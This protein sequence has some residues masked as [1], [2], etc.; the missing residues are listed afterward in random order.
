[1]EGSMHRLPGIVAATAL[2]L[3]VSSVS[4]RAADDGL[5]RI[6]STERLI[7]LNPYGDSN[8]QMYSIWC[9]IYGCLG[10]Y[11]WEQKKYVGMLAEKWEVVGPTTWRF[12]L[13]TDLKRQDG[14]PGPK[15]KDVV[16]AF[17][18]I[19]TD[20]ESTQKSIVADVADVTAVDDTTVDFHTKAPDAPFLS[21]LFDRFVVTSADL[22]ETYGKDADKKG[23][24]GWGPY[25]LEDFVLD[26]RVVL[27]R[28]DAWPGIDPKT[29]KKVIYQTIMEP[30][31]R[32]TALLNGEVEIARLIPPQLVGRLQNRP[33]IKIVKTDSIEQ[34]FIGLN[35]NFKPWDDV[36]VR[37]AASHAID[38]DL[39][40]Q[41]LLNNE[42]TRLDGPVGSKPQLCYNGGVK[43]AYSYDP[44]LAKKLLAEAGYA[45]G[46][47]EIEFLTPSNRFIADKQAS[48][49]MAQMLRAVGF[50]V[51]LQV[52]EY[53]NLWAAVRP[54]KAP[55]Y[56]FARGSVFDATDSM[57]QYFE[58][59]GSPRI[60]YTNP[61][62]DAIIARIRQEF[63]EKKRCDLMNEAAAMVVNDAPVIQLWTHTLVSGVRKDITYPA[64]PSGEVWLLGVRL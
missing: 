23:A 9:Q 45:D 36:R 52:L 58:T 12:H 47:P 51:K 29:P 35:N 14:G 30:E 40:I 55:T 34:M 26:Q 19:M 32:V 56:Y 27:A 13:R 6:S 50:K 42:A 41:K 15:A 49:V 16:H 46:G 60:N 24:I 28:N 43:G 5:L 22:F 4:P 59:G 20:P 61:K 44:A 17:K 54:G 3:L 33:D 62:F 31:Q 39:I 21:F 48:E 10:V 11:D 8:G 63:D 25:K 64:N 53:A 2:F 38:R 7:T 1:M 37:R 57:S 18:R